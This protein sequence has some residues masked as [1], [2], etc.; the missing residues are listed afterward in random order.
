MEE[1]ITY[2]KAI[3]GEDFNY[4]RKFGMDITRDGVLLK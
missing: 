4:Y 2:I 3:E 1:E